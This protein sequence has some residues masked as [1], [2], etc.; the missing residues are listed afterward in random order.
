MPSRAD[1]ETRLRGYAEE[2]DRAFPST[3]RV[4]G[5]IMARISITPRD[6]RAARVAR[7]RWS[8][9]GVLVR[10]LA[11]VCVLLGAVGGLVRGGTK[12]GAGERSA[13]H[14]HGVPGKLAVY[15]AAM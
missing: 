10:Q 13:V 11:M 14:S 7:P 3:A 8:L 5:R 15:V 12:L 6:L 1:V 2:Y 9:A 4:E